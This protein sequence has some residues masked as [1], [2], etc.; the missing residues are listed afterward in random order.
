MAWS[1][2]A[3]PESE[4]EVE[5]YKSSSTELFAAWA[6]PTSKALQRDNNFIFLG[7]VFTTRS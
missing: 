5:T 2:L 3:L 4:S 6:M 1:V 7:N